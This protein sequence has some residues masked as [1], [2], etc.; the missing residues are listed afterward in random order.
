M[1]SGGSAEDLESARQSLRA[2]N[3]LLSDRSEL[4]TL[5]VDEKIDN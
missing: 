3:W 5:T 2:D 1:N 4:T